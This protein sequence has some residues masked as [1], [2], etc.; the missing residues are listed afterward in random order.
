MSRKRGFKPGMAIA[1][2]I[3]NMVGT[4]V[5]TSLGF[6][7]V[8]IQS[9]FVLLLLW[10]VGGIAAL[11]GALTYAELSARMPRSGGEYNFLSQIYHPSMGFISGWISLTVGFAAPTALAAM[12]FAAYLSAALS[13]V[14]EINRELAAISL[15]V[16]LTVVHGF[17]THASGGI[18]QWF[19]V[20]KVVLIILFCVLVSLF[21]QVP[22]EFNLVPVSSD[23]KLITSGSFAVSLIYVNYA[24]TGWNAA[25]YITNEV[26]DPQKNTPLIMVVGTLTVMTLYILLNAVFLYST[27]AEA[28]VGKIEIGLIVAE[29]TF[30]GTGGVMMGFVLSLMLISTV[31]AMIMAGPRVLQVIGEDF[32]IFKWLS[33][34]F[35]E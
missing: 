30:G 11:S 3:A 14:I 13:D 19:T 18:Q 29:R 28:M 32:S 8:D 21:A 24:Y 1:L 22:H 5:F 25:T 33:K 17:S 2:V 26:E 9:I 20:I 23:L 4:G 10:F 6:Q 31:S 15:V 34:V 27:P 35:S 12:T 16:V 7:L